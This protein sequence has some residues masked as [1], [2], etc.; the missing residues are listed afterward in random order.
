MKRNGREFVPREKPVQKIELSEKYIK[1]R[2]ILALVCLVLGLGLMGYGL[3]SALNTDPTWQEITASGSGAH[4]G[5]DFQLMY[6]FSQAGKNAT[7]QEKILTNLYSQAAVDGYR[8]FTPDMLEEGLGNVA[9]LNAHVNETVT[10]EPGLYRALE[11]VV[12]SGDRQ[13]YLAPAAEQY[14]HVFSSQSDGEAEAY[15]PEKNEAQGQWFSTLAAFVADPAA[16]DVILYGENRAM[17]FVSEEYLAFARENEIDR[18]LDF[19]WMTNAFLADYLAQ[20]L[21]ENGFTR[22][23]LTSVDGFTRNLDDG[24]TKYYV[25]LLTGQG[26]SLESPGQICYQGP[27]S[28]VLLRRFDL[29]EGD[30]YT[31]ASGET[32][33]A[34]L[35]PA[36]CRSKAATDSLLA[37]SSSA[38]CAQLLLQVT[39]LYASDSLDVQ[40]I[41]DLRSAD[42]YAVWCQDKTVSYNDPSLDLRLSENGGYTE[43]FLK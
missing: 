9:W 38:G 25:N 28:L 15:D 16:V 21:V 27:M 42:I 10:V 30:R 39:R 5:E 18:F 41:N 11:Q 17:L 23:Y 12:S 7:A 29:G 32:V 14:R 43:N 37:Y 26:T 20:T 8:A 3:L 35:D 36:D 19:G 13:V 2:G 24:D 31:Y 33:T 40:G 6:D 4:C 34:Y 1:P 22:G